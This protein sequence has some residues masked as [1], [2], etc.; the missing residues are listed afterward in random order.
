MAD[1][2][3]D[4]EVRGLLRKMR[5]YNPIPSKFGGYR[6][7]PAQNVIEDIFN[8]DSRHSYFIQAV[9][10]IAHLLY[11]REYPKGSLKKHGVDLWFELLEPLL[12]KQAAQLD[13]F[14]I[15]RK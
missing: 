12:V 15:V 11:R 10:T 7:I 1:G 8:R 3:E 2:L 5:V 13:P 14:G 9:D 6:D 4:M